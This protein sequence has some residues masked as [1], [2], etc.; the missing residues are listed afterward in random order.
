MHGLYQI[1][2]IEK[3][4]ELFG[5]HACTHPTRD[6]VVM[7]PE[8]KTY[9]VGMIKHVTKKDRNGSQVYTSFSHVEVHVQ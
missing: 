2:V 1:K 9:S 4:V 6:Q 3:G 8:G 7:S 5:Y